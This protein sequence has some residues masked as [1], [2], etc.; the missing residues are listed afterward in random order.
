MPFT[1]VKFEDYRSVWAEISFQLNPA[2]LFVS[3]GWTNAWWGEYGGDFS[4]L[5][6]AY[7][8]D[9]WL[10]GLAPLKTKANIASFIGSPE[11][12]D[13]QD[14]VVKQGFEKQ[15]IEDIIKELSFRGFTKLVFEALRADSPTFKYITTSTNKAYHVQMIDVSLEMLLPSN[16]WQ[17]MQSL[18]SKQRH[19]ITRKLRRLSEA[20][21]VN[22]R[23]ETEPRGLNTLFKQIQGSR[24]DKARFMDSKRQRY[25][26][27]LAIEM[28]KEG[29]LRL[30]FLDL[31]GVPIATII[32]FDYNNR[33]YLYNSGYESSYSHLSP[34]LLS[35]VLS[36]KESIG[37]NRHVYDFLKGA[38]V[39]KYRL[40]GN[41]VP[42][43]HCELDL[44]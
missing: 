34:G 36:I 12:C 4:Q 10:A 33:I 42:L 3:P 30:G 23:I 26:E 2:S 6:L 27:K 31:D 14:F 28:E 15:F 41:E 8:I 35:K 39:Y 40:N 13:Y 18:T 24:A 22:L 21:E 19:E 9:D 38:E 5:L 20:G 25:F 7:R 32:F 44:V 17:F 43:Y 37:S 16:W 1:L 29:Y 11:V